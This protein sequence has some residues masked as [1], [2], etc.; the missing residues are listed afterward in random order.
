MHKPLATALRAALVAWLGVGSPG[1]AA[2]AVASGEALFQGICRACHGF[3]PAGGPET[4]AGDATRIVAAFDKRPPMSSLRGVLSPADISDITEYLSSL[5]AAASALPTH[6]FSDL[7]WNAAESGWGLSITQHANGATFGVL[8]VY[9]AAKRPT[10]YALPG[11][12]WTTPGTFVG[13]LYAASGPG[14]DTGPFDAAAVGVRQ[15][16]AM[17]ITF[18]DRDRATL[19]YTVDNRLHTRSITRQPF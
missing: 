5:D 12:R 14:F 7:W 3:P 16:G 6:D 4:I 13:R 1:A 10:W 2:Q 9:D 11:G 17:R 15:V 19:V 18:D 8:F